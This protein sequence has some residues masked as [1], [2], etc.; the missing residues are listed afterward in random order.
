MRT[1]RLVE[2]VHADLRRH[3]RA[4]DLAVDATLGNG[5]DAACLVQCVGPT[6][7]VWGFDVQERAL[8]ATRERLGD[9]PGFAAV[10]ADHARMDEHLPKDVRGRLRAVVFNLGWLPGGDHALTTRTASTLAA[11]EVALAWLAPDGVLSC[12]AYRG[13]PGGQ[14]EARAV[15]ARLAAS[16]GRLTRVAP[17]GTRE[18]APLWLWFERSRDHPPR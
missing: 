1:P 9:V 6:G 2:R 11:V 3:L 12:L 14:Q 8:S 10:Q 17:E 7:R 4:G 13:H 18:P 15:D 5:H 16:A